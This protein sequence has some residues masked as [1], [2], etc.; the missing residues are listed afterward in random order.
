MFG[1]MKKSIIAGIIL[2]F[3]MAA[4]S[5]AVDDIYDPDLLRA[6]R[7]LLK[8][9]SVDNKIDT[10]FYIADH[11]GS[12][13]KDEIKLLSYYI[14]ISVNESL[15]ESYIG[16]AINTIAGM[17]PYARPALL[18]LLT[19]RRDKVRTR[20]RYAIERND[21]VREYAEWVIPVLI[22]QL[23]TESNYF[24]VIRLLKSAGSTAIPALVV[25]GDTL[26][27]VPDRKERDRRERSLRK[28]VEELENEL[29]D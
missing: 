2:V 16:S 26:S 11:V 28:I 20:V 18:A 14:M 29:H 12:A 21:D 22:K 17:G 7:V 9:G 1:Y 15:D 3:N 19:D 10:L 25:G 23:Y 13:E 24:V 27:L 6:G 5:A 4:D 8:G